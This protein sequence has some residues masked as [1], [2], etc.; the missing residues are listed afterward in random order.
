MKKTDERIEKRSN[1]LAA[2]L[3]F[4][5]LALQVILNVVVCTNLVPCTGISL[6]FF[7]YGGS[8]VVTLFMAMGVV[9]GIKMRSPAMRRLGRPIKN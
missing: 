5:M 6:P 1:A 2:K 8:S 7:S 9:S 4:V 3:L